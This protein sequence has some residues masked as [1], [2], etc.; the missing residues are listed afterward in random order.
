M[1]QNTV[2]ISKLQ[3]ICMAWPDK[4][5]VWGSDLSFGM[6]TE[7]TRIQI[8]LGPLFVFLMLEAHAGLLKYETQHHD[9]NFLF[10]NMGRM[11]AAFFFVN[12]TLTLHAAT[13]PL[14]ACSELQ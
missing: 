9:H 10:I 8:M 1:F 6:G 12:L 3:G 14:I 4:Q 7:V 11:L 5:W 13:Y 2:L